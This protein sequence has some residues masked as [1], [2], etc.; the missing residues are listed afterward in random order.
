MNKEKETQV[1]ILIAFFPSAAQ[2]SR[3][4]DH[5]VLPVCYCLMYVLFLLMCTRTVSNTHNKEVHRDILPTEIYLSTF[6]CG[7]SSK[8][9]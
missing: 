5:P 7:V 4:E 3:R 1:V 6:G 2:H 8:M 9:L